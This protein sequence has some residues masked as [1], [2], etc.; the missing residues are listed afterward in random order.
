MI[1]SPVRERNT[2]NPYSVSAADGNLEEERVVISYR[3]IPLPLWADDS[4]AGRFVADLS[5]AR[6][7]G[8]TVSG[9]QKSSGGAWK[10]S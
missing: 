5:V 6:A 4:D 8:G 7:R 3:R 1:G 2:G 10:Q 9:S